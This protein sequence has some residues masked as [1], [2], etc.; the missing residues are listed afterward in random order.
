MKNKKNSKKQQLDAKQVESY[1][2]E[3]KNFFN[4]REQL[5]SKFNLPH[6]KKGSISLI[7]RQ[8][9]ILR[10]ENKAQKDKL[11]EFIDTGAKNDKISKK[12]LTLATSL[13]S[14]KSQKNTFEE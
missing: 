2:M 12:I 4:A 9:E 7:E 10:E 3:N 13:I 14:S 6:N 5:I 1:L 8:I 11:I